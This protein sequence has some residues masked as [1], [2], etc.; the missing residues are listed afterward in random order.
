MKYIETYKVFEKSNIEDLEGLRFDVNMIF[1][2]EIS[3]E[4][5]FKLSVQTTAG[6]D[7]TWISILL[8]DLRDYDGFKLSEVREFLLRLKDYLGNRFGK[9]SILPQGCIERIEVDITR[10]DNIDF[11]IANLSVRVL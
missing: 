3:N 11:Y 1:L 5:R 2:S 6:K 10:V 9:I 8:S 4:D 7:K